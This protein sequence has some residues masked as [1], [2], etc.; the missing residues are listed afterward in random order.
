MTSFTTVPIVIATLTIT[1]FAPALASNSI[2]RDGVDDA[3]LNLLSTGREKHSHLTVELAA[4]TDEAKNSV[5]VDSVL[6]V[7]SLSN[8]T[9]NHHTNP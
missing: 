5:L 2:K 9:H 4:Q 1:L 6:E 3:L 7:G 8:F